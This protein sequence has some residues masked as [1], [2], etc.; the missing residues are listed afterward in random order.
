MGCLPLYTFD[1][2]IEERSVERCLLRRRSIK[3]CCLIR[4]ARPRIEEVTVRRVFGTCASGSAC[5]GTL[6]TNSIARAFYYFLFF[7]LL[8]HHRAITIII[9]AAK[10]TVILYCIFTMLVVI[11]EGRTALRVRSPRKG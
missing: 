10:T 1:V 4:L 5:P 2:G 3:F 11:D 7:V 8:A 6:A 9:Y